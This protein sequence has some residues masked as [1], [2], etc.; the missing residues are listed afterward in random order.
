LNRGLG[1]AI[2]AAGLLI[3]GCSL[4][5]DITPPAALATA[6]MAAVAKPPTAAPLIPPSTQPNLEAGAVIYAE[7]CAACHGLQGLGDGEL[8]EGLAFAPAPLGDPEFARQADP[9]EWYSTVTIGN[10][11][12]LMPGFVS[13]TDQQRW[14]VVGYALG[15]SESLLPL[16][17]AEESRPSEAELEAGIVV[18]RVSNGSQGGLLP[19][20]RKVSLFGYDGDQEVV[21]ETTSLNNDGSFR[22]EGLEYAPGR[23]FFATVVHDGLTYRS[24]VAHVTSD[25]ITLELPITVYEAAED[26]SALR[27]ERLHLILDFTAEDKLA[28]L[29][30]WV[31]ANDSDRVITTPIQIALPE[32]ASNLTF[33]RG[34]LGGRFEITRDGFADREPLPPGSGPEPLVF[35][36]DLP[37][38]RSTK[39]EQPMRHPVEAVNVFTPADGPRV[40]GLEDRGIQDIGGLRMRSYAEGSLA[41]EEL[42]SFQV[43]A[44]SFGSGIST[45]EIVGAGTL[46]IAGLLAARLWVGGRSRKLAGEDLLRE[47]ARLD[48]KYEAGQLSERTWRRRRG[49]LKRQ[50]LDQMRKAD[51]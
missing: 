4:A 27:V 29:E 39:F 25:E 16:N 21:N 34:S 23:L 40:T 15:L 51:D 33:E 50:A 6:Q 13:L 7:K 48:D 32:G 38:S 18:G 12:R 1:P 31:L 45:A 30:V 17:A 35:G 8:A 11:N 14:D 36:F 3:G 41:A 2:L 9:G 47:I 44:P 5:G 46:V 37:V 49:P 22:I 19:A 26:L 42:L 20:D 43:S 10:L 24:D 28:V